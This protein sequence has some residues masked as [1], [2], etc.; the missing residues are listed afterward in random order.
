MNE[1]QMKE[2]IRA[3]SSALDDALGWAEAVTGH[4]DFNESDTLQ[5]CLFVLTEGEEGRSP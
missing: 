1:Q 3:L 4:Q 5:Y 2:R